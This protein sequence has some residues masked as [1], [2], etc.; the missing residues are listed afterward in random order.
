MIIENK[1]CHGSKGYTVTVSNGEFDY[2]EMAYC[3]ALNI[4]HTQNINNYAAIIDKKTFEQ[5][6]DRHRLVFDFIIVV[7]H[8]GFDREWQ[9]KNLSPW[10]Q[11]VKLDVDILFPRSIDH[12][13]NWFEKYDVLFANTIRDFRGEKITSRWHRQL[14][15]INLLP[16][17][18]TAF[19]YFKES[20]ITT[21]FF[22]DVYS[23]S[24]NWNWFANEFLIKN[25]DPTPRDDEIFSLAVLLNGEENFVCPTS[26]IPQFVHLK[27]SLNALPSNI[28]WHEQIYFENNDH[29]FWIGHYRQMWPIHYCSK[30]FNIKELIDYYERNNQKPS[31]GTARILAA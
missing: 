4:K 23:I 11:T 26:V 2:L 13:W 25:I 28:P 31:Q 3:Q 30:T 15:D 1:F 27:E 16:D 19:Y 24:T 18:Y 14:F 6:Q 22:K 9:V 17:I 5:I 20:N 7:D 12:W 21:E 10:K 8:W 29:E